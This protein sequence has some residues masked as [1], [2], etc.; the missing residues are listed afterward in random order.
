MAEARRA[1][2][3]DLAAALLALAAAFS[4]R[5]ALSNILLVFTAVAWVVARRRGRLAGR[6]RARVLAGPLLAFAFF[7]VVSA[8]FSL[9]PLFSFNQLPRLAVLLVVPV[10]ASLLDLV[11]WRRFVVILAAAATI[12]ASWG[13]IQYLQGAND[14]ANRIRG[15]LSHYMTFSGWL[16]LAVLVLVSELL[17]D[18][19]R[20]WPWLLPP[21]ALGTV[22]LLLSYTRN[23][24]I[25]LA[26]GGLLLAAV[27]RRR[28]LLLYPVAA[29]AVW[30]VF[31]QAV[32]DRAL[33]ILDL[34]QHANYDRVC[35]MVAGTK[36][37][38]DHPFTGVGPGMVKRLYPLYRVDD[39]PR[40]VV[41]HLHDNAMQIAAE[42]GLPALAAYLWLLGAF[43]VRTWRA[44]PR[45]EPRQRAA[46]AAGVVAI[47][48]ITV[49]GLFEY[50][51]WDAEVQYLTLTIMG[52]TVGLATGAER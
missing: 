10:A 47:A 39:A 9:D 28:L 38:R 41:P 17:L 30:L 1:G 25:G 3:A 33:S 8:V 50:N 27:W 11:W 13:I 37:V 12:L 52:G 5:L 51:F 4:W 48:G 6:P 49:A 42:R 15:P 46:V 32:T 16:L 26:V 22:A 45:L 14:L 24:W 23:A 2:S 35:M 20:R 29:L 19:R 43:F 31:P 18:P 40:W 44:L 34:R 36:M 7:S 21:I